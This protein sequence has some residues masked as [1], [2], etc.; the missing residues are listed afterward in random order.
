MQ[1]N[2]I[3]P[4]FTGFVRL[5]NLKDNSY[6]DP[7]NTANISSI[8]G[9]KYQDCGTVYQNRICYTDNGGRNRQII[10]TYR[11]YQGETDPELPYGKDFEDA[12]ARTCAEADKTGEILNIAV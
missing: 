7:I 2:G 3:S 11:E 4:N 1:I 6:T 9:E 10:N 12:V 5:H 8:K